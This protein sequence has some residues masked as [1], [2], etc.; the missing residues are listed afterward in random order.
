MSKALPTAFLSLV[1]ILPLQGCL[2]ETT[3]DMLLQSTSQLTLPLG[4]IHTPPQDSGFSLQGALAVSGGRGGSKPVSLSEQEDL[5]SSNQNNTAEI[6]GPTSLS[7]E[8]LQVSG[9]VSLSLVDHVRLGIGVDGSRM[10]VAPWGE[11]GARFGRNTSVEFFTA[12]GLVPVETRSSWSQW[13]QR[14][15][16]EDELNDT[17][18]VFREYDETDNRFF[19]RTG[20]HV[21]RKAGGPWAEIQITRLGLLDSPR[22]SSSWVA[23]FLTLGTGWAQPTPFGTWTAFA[24]A[25][26]TRGE[27]MPQLG[28]QW[29]GE[30]RLG[31]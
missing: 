11:I 23:T 13:T 26:S 6:M 5:G 24:R 9:N 17:S 30:M 25:T 18:T 3:H 1:A 15:D 20:V 8:P 12:A 10:G 21:A 22:A 16:P 19:F 31:R 28:L 2:T 7:T 4:P 27:W 29:T 14:V